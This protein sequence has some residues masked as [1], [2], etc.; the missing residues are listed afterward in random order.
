MRRN[1]L[2]FTTLAFFVGLAARAD[3]L[4]KKVHKPGTQIGNGGHRLI[5]ESTKLYGRRGRSLLGLSAFAQASEKTIE[6]TYH[7]GN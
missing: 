5:G 7:Q 6:A 1:E 4:T 3:A 2:L